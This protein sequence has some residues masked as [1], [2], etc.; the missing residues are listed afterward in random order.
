VF[1]A[2]MSNEFANRNPPRRVFFS[3]SVNQ[4]GRG[5]D[6]ASVAEKPNQQAVREG[7]KAPPERERG[8]SLRM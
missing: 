1:V 6:L 5:R 4:G 7:A 3:R 2:S 8:D